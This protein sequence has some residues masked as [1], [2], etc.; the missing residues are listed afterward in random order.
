MVEHKVD[1]VLN[2]GALVNSNG[3]TWDHLGPSIKNVICNL[4][5]SLRY[6]K[7]GGSGEREGGVV[8]LTTTKS[9]SLCWH[10]GC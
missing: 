1:P 8:P 7:P 5:H 6:A 10:A 2:F 9:S 4:T 3:T